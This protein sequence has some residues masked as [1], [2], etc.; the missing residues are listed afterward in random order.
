MSDQNTN[1]ATGGTRKISVSV[2]HL[3]QELR[4][5]LSRRAEDLGFSV[6]FI[7]R[8]LM[9]KKTEDQADAGEK[10]Q[11]DW[12]KDSEV[13]LTSRGRHVEKCSDTLKWAAD[14]YAGMDVYYP[15]EDGT[16]IL[17][18]EGIFLTNSSG[19]YG[20]TIS[21]HIIMA[22]LMLWRR[23]PEYMECHREQTWG[24]RLELGSIMGSTF[25]VLGAGDIGTTFAKKARALGAARI[26][27]VSRTGRVRYPGVYD[28]MH[29]FTELAGVLPEADA[30][31]MSLPGTKETVGMMNMDMF[32]LMKK[33]AILV[34]VGR[35]LSVV[36][37]DLVEALNTGIISGAAVDVMEKEPLPQGDPLWT[38]KKC[39]VTPHVAGNMTLKTTRQLIVDLFC[40]NL[41][42]YVNGEKLENLM[43]LTRGY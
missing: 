19:V 29:G 11:L 4:D 36:Q 17:P 6:K 27:G 41:Q 35:G 16:S 14:T 32:R 39:V 1:A 12:L 25:V 15:R 28:E 38:A 5:D 8:H 42:H 13:I 22:L 30:V 23:E 7:D 24:P 40:R 26:I 31:V 10:A 34:N 20:P 21:E 33:S 18:H 43:D 2:S 9:E 3:E 37:K